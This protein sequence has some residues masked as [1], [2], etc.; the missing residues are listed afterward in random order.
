VPFS[1]PVSLIGSLPVVN[2]GPGQFYGVSYLIKAQ[3]AG[4]TGAEFAVC[5]GNQGGGPCQA[6]REAI[7]SG[8][9]FGPQ[10]LTL[11]GQDRT[12]TFQNEYIQNFTFN[13]GGPFPS[14]TDFSLQ[15]TLPD[16]FSVE[17]LGPAVPEPSTWAMMLLGFAS[18]GFMAYR[19]KSKWPSHHERAA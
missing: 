14:P 2:A 7:N 9:G 17:G 15:I 10:T 12:I 13:Y 6:A 3:V 1:I 5:G 16:A 11:S 19:R 8:F 4:I 18:I